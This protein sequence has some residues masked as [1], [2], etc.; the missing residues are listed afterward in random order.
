MLSINQQGNITEGAHLKLPRHIFSV[1]VRSGACYITGQ[2]DRVH[3]KI[4]LTLT[5]TPNP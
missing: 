5:L 2:S 4:N 1:Q 3:N